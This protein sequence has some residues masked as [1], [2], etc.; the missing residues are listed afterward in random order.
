MW[1]HNGGIADFSRLKRKLQDSLPDEAFD[2]VQ[3]NT[4]F[5]LFL[6]LR[7]FRLTGS[8][9]GMGICFI[10]FKGISLQTILTQRDSRKVYKLPNINADTFPHQTLQKAMLDTIAHLNRLA[11]AYNVVEVCFLP[12]LIQ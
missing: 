11:K 9:F 7:N 5:P 3:G 6:S 8:R 1:M 12:R 4:G 2:V 10:S